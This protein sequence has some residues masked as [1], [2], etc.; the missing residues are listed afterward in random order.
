[1]S[2]LIDMKWGKTFNDEQLEVLGLSV[3]RGWLT[4]FDIRNGTIL[5][6]EPGFMAILGPDPG[7][8]VMTLLESAPFMYQN[9]GLLFNGLEQILQLAESINERSK[10]ESGQ[11]HPIAVALETSI[12][13]MQNFILNARRAAIIGMDQFAKESS[14]KALTPTR[15]KR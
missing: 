5:P 15:P 11:N 3:V 12:T 13:Q 6:G 1:M 8:K 14:Q 4:A 7:L 9:L 10:A 2:N